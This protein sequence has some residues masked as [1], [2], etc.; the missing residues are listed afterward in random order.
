M[1]IARHGNVFIIKRPS[2][3]ATS[4]GRN[5]LEAIPAMP[6]DDSLETQDELRLVSLV[7]APNT[8]HLLHAGAEYRLP[9]TRAAQRRSRARP[10]AGSASRGP[11]SAAR[12]G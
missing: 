7:V 3:N 5:E 10:S 1:A 12:A 11:V 9:A 6:K 2:F 4:L 8:G